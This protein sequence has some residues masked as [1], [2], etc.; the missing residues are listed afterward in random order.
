MSSPF[1]VD[2]ASVQ[3]AA[4][5]VRST[6]QEVGGDLRTL[7]GVVGELS[8]AW[9]GSASTAYQG[10]MERWNKDANN[11]LQ[12]LDLIADLLHKAANQHAQNEDQQRQTMNKFDV[13]S[14]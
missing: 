7:S 5:E 12:S 8:G 1:S 14:G 6:R 9:K 13:L 3:A 10:V 2:T 4:Q 11:L